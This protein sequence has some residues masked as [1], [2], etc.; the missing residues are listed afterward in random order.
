MRAPFED[1][2][3]TRLAGFR[4]LAVDVRFGAAAFFFAAAA[5]LLGAAGFLFGAAAFFFGAARFF[6]CDFVGF[7]SSSCRP[8]I[9]AAA[10]ARDTVGDSPGK[11]IGLIASER[12]GFASG[13]D[14]SL[15]SRAMGP[16]SNGYVI[17]ATR[18][19][20]R[21]R[22]RVSVSS[23]SMWLQVAGFLLLC[24]TA[25]YLSWQVWKSALRQRRR[26]SWPKVTGKVIEQRM[27]ETSRG[28]SLDYLVSYEHGGET[29]QVACTDWSPG[30]YTGPEETH[31][32]AAFEE[33]MRK[34]LDAYKAGDPIP[35]MVNPD[36]PRK[37]F[38]KRG[39]T[40][41]LTA[42]AVAVTV[43]FVVLVAMLTPVI[44]QAP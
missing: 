19:G 35:L 31:G 36:N 28:R 37:A 10:I 13:A 4:A 27:K 23:G 30:L 2:A 22:R 25:G 1:E 29:F 14:F 16:P 9:C 11:G 43:V 7:S 38:Y 15:L 21:F 8:Y 41:P 18:A 33:S 39:R 44:F 6:G 32:Q 17:V 5:F 24:F 34:R 12:S 20:E 42:L 3:E 26:E 40:W